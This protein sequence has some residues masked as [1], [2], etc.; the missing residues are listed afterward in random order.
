[1]PK[2]KTLFV[3]ND[4]LREEARW[5]LHAPETGSRAKAAGALGI[6]V[7]SFGRIVR[8]LPVQAETL[9]HARKALQDMGRLTHFDSVATG[10]LP[11]WIVRPAL[12][13]PAYTYGY[14][15]MQIPYNRER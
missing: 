3:P 12:R 8:G 5:L 9:N 15:L 4:V 13:E 10:E 2:R 6:S 1:M 7:R 11:A 14:R